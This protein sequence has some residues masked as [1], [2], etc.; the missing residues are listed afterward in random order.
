MHIITI[1]ARIKIGSI[2]GP[3]P[4]IIGIGPIRKIAPKLPV[5]SDNNVAKAIKTAPTEI[6]MK[7]RRNRTSG[8]IHFKAL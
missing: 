6:T 8:V 2:W 3:E 4:K 5:L 7:L 1:K